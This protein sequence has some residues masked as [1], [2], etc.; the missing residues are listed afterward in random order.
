MYMLVINDEQFMEGII[1]ALGWVIAVFYIRNGMYKHRIKNSNMAIVGGL[2]WAIMWFIRKIGGN[3]YKNIKKQNKIQ[4]KNF[5]LPIDSTK[6]III[7]FLILFVLL[8]FI[9]FRYTKK[10]NKLLFF[11]NYYEIPLI[12]F[13][14]IFG[15]FIFNN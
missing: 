12:S 11:L 1:G 7:S 10:S 4:D 3:L 2:T 8:Y 14:V 6:N 13:V 15:I 9:V 5:R